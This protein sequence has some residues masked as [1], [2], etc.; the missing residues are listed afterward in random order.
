M[1]KNKFN[2]QQLRV[3]Q[4]RG[5]NLLVS[6]S[7]GT[8]KTTVMIERLFSLVKDDG[9]DLSQVMV[10]TFTKLAAAEMKNRLLKKL[11]EHSDDNF[12]ATQL[13]KI[14]SCAISTVHSFCS[15]V[16]RN[17]FYV[18]DVDPSFSV[19]DDASVARLQRQAAT[20]VL[21]EYYEKDDEQFDRLFHIFNAKRSDE[22]LVDYLLSLYGES[23]SM[24]DFYGWYRSCRDNFLVF[25]KDNKLEKAVVD[26]VKINFAAYR[27]AWEGYAAFYANEGL[28]Q[29]ADFCN[30][31]VYL[32]SIGSGV[33]LEQTRNVLQQF[34]VGKIPS[35]AQFGAK[36]L[37]DEVKENRQNALKKLNKECKDYVAKWDW[38]IEAE[39]LEKLREQTRATVEHTDKIVEVLGKFHERFAAL[40]KQRNGVDFPDLEHFALAILSDDEARAEIRSRFR[41][42]FVDEYQDINEV[43]EAV[44]S[45]LVQDG[46]A[47][48]VGDVKQSIYGF[49][50]CDSRIFLDK[51]AH[52]AKADG[53][54]SLVT[55]NKNYRSDK[56]I[57]DFVNFVM[58]YAMTEDFG[59]VDYAATSR[60][61]GDLVKNDG[62][63]AVEIS[64][65]S[66]GSKKTEE[67][68]GIY[69]LTAPI[70]EEESG[71]RAEGREV[72]EKIRSF[73]GTT[74]KD[75]NDNDH[76]VDY[77]DIVILSRGMRER[78]METYRVLVEN[79]VPVSATFALDGL[80]S[81]EV[82]DVV[83]FLRVLDNPYDDVH[84]VGTCLSPIGGFDEA[85]LGKVCLL[86]KRSKEPFCEKLRTYAATCKDDLGAKISDFLDFVDKMRFCSTSVSVDELVLRLISLCRYN[87]HVQGLPN[88]QLRVGKLYS[89]IDEIKGQRY[90]QSVSKFL[91]FVDDSERNANAG[92]ATGA[93][94]VRMMTMHASK[95]LEFP[96]V[97]VIGANNS[98]RAE[99]QTVEKNV[100]VGLGMKYYDFDSM[101]VSESLAHFGTS[102]FNAVKSLEEELRLLYV[103]LTRAQNHLVIVG[104]DAER[105]LD[106]RPCAPQLCKTP[107]EWIARGLIAKFGDLS[108]ATR[109]LAEC[110]I[111]VNVRNRLQG[112]VALPDLVGTQDESAESAL[113]A[114]DYRYPYDVQTAIPAKV[115]SSALDEARFFYGSS[116]SA[117]AE[118]VVDDVSRQ[119]LGT[120]Y[121][122]VYE[123]IDYDSDEQAVAELVERLAEGGHFS[124]ECAELVDVSLVANTLKN[125]ILREIIEGGKVYRELPFM[126]KADYAEL[127]GEQS[128]ETV[129]QGVLDLLVVKKDKAVVV[130]F[131]YTRSSRNL[132]ERYRYQLKSYKTAVQ[133]IL[134]IPN[135]ETYLLSIMDNKIVKTD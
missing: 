7:A 133:R 85:Q 104:Y 17:F 79:N 5:E 18:V 55:L 25:G 1:A 106:A 69:D 90:A 32:L 42:V 49:R 54:G 23:R 76:V 45:A 10:V 27:A 93:K 103:A 105:L 89:F 122:K 82:R 127:G 56:R 72:L 75:E 22:F 35:K 98:P 38:L 3:I 74:I 83:N 121:H 78:A 50:G 124:R 108:Q 26:S 20:E 95:G 91:Q 111:A 92:E 60:L 109:R 81:K 87:L 30:D 71:G 126:M 15:D 112:A 114:L 52:Y 117:T 59:K 62:R 113:A 135:V 28:E 107:A 21:E 63:A 4:S 37:P 9:V 31:Y 19:L 53:C 43:Q 77:G 102:T 11:S 2:P 131:K 34:A 116:D 128:G 58:D 13:E 132:P 110:G 73:V 97:I 51:M 68:S 24:A 70:K 129:L 47:F 65:L 94:A 86:T 44:I 80:Q 14:D 46:K 118:V 33:D 57:L 88:G 84:F 99:T 29:V 101:K 100:D 134:K 36:N 125:P 67:I 61:D 41:Y 64:F 6:A 130:D 123:E 40:K 12:V 96:I 66:G 8:G 115:A 120:A 119:E 16:L 48:M 39:S